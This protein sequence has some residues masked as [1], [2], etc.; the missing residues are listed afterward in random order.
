MNPYLL[1]ALGVALASANNVLLHKFGNRGLRGTGDSLFFN[2]LVSAVW[3]AVLFVIQLVSGGITLPSRI[4]LLLGAL[5]G[6][7]TAVFLTSKMQ[8]LAT[9][10]VAVTT[11]ISCSGM[12]LPTFFGPL[13]YHEPIYIEQ[14]IG[15]VLLFVSLFVATDFKGEKKPSKSWKFYC[16]ILVIFAGSVGVIFK[17]HQYSSGKAEIDGMM[18]T[19]S[20]TAALLL[21]FASLFVAR[22]EKLYPPRVSGSGLL[23]MVGCGIVSC[24]YCRLNI[25]LSGQMDS[26]ILFPTFNGCLILAMAIVGF[27]VF[28]EKPTP[29]KIAGLALGALSVVL[30]SGAIRIF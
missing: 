17:I 4:S 28:G 21:L 14:V 6:V 22:R 12:V 29:R 3:L 30:V 26:M 19:A 15:V 9:G 27:V 18:S 23:Y 13:A 10:P 8:A 7:V 20:I 11:L 24:G 1:L 25:Y 2:S 16:I 5:Y